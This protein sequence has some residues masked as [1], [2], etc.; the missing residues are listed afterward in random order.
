MTK[1]TLF[2]QIIQRLDRSIFIKL[3]KEHSTDKHN[4]GFDS[5]SYLISMILQPFVENAIKHGF[6]NINYKGLIAINVVKKR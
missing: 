6:A 3:V 2:A 1:I 5:W 4:K